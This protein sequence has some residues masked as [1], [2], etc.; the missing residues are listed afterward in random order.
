MTMGLPAPKPWHTIHSE[1]GPDLT[2]FKVRY[3]TVQNPSNSLEMKAVILETPDWVNVI[4]VTRAGKILDVDQYRFGVQ[5][6]RQL[7][8]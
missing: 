5:K 8:K 6:I 3:D 2:I 7:K 1:T 4:A